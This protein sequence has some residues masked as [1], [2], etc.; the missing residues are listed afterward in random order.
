MKLVNR[1]RQEIHAVWVLAL[2]I[3]ESTGPRWPEV[4]RRV[5]TEFSSGEKPERGCLILGAHYDRARAR[6]WCTEEKSKS[7]LTLVIGNFKNFHYSLDLLIT[8]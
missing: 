2:T 4:E 1:K 8:H 3:F 5:T 7:S 6:A